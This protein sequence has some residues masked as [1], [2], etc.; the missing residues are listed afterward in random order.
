MLK[1]MFM[2]ILLLIMI[3]DFCVVYD[4]NVKVKEFE[5]Y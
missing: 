3:K 5:Y 1:M 4:M 2:K